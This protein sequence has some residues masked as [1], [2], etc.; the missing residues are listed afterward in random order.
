LQSPKGKVPFI[1]HGGQLVADS[2]IILGYLTRTF[3]GAG[4]LGK[5]VPW[6]EL[7][8]Q[9]QAVGTALRVLTEDHL[10]WAGIYYTVRRLFFVTTQRWFFPLSRWP[11]GAAV[12]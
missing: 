2:E 11:L 3:A 12:C 10:Y 8:P 7:T 6:H 1:E 9:Q 4:K 5:L